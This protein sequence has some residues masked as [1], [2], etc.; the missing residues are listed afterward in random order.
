M[1]NELV[2]RDLVLVTVLLNKLAMF[3]E[4]LMLLDKL[5]GTPLPLL[6]LP[7][8]LPPVLPRPGL[9]DGLLPGRYTITIVSLMTD[10]L[11]FG[12]LL[13]C[14]VRLLVTPDFA[15]LIDLLPA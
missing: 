12:R 3:V 6:P 8:K 9:F 10:P 4:V 11:A 15:A 2:R 7:S 14:R 5:L 13:I 1:Q